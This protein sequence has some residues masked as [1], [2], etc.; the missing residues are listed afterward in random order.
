MS[1]I[2]AFRTTSVA[3]P[4]LRVSARGRSRSQ[5][6]VGVLAASVVF[7]GFTYVSYCAASLAGS[8]M[9]EQARR[10]G[11]DAV[12]RAKSAHAAELNLERRLDAMRS[13]SAIDAWAAQNGFVASDRA[14][15]TSLDP[16]NG[17]PQT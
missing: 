11:L 1:A 9:A 2:P 6:R 17:K 7:L 16:K 4:S 13:L 14:L 3:V 10:Q 8:V 5:P 12:A 15:P